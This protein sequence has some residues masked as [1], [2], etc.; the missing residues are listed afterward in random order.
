MRIPDVSIVIAT[1]NRSALLERTLTSILEQDSSEGSFEVIVVDNN[2]SDNTYGMVQALQRTAGGRLRYLTESRQGNAYAR[3]TG[4]SAALAPVIAF[5]DDDVCVSP[6]W[7][8]TI[9]DAFAR[10]DSASFIGGRVLPDWNGVPPQWLTRENWAPIAAV[11]YGEE[12]VA[13]NAEHSVCLLTANLAIRRS[14]LD[15]IG[16]FNPSLQRVKEGIGSLEDH[17]LIARLCRAGE[18]GVYLPGMCASTHIAE[19][20]LSK[21]YHRRWHRGHGKFYAILRDPEFERSRSLIFRAPAHVYR[22]M[23]VAMIGW[24]ACM[25]LRRTH[26][27]FRFESQLWFS[28]GYLGQRL[29]EEQV[30]EAG[31]STGKQGN[32]PTAAEEEWGREPHSLSLVGRTISMDYTAAFMDLAIGMFMLPFNMAHL[33]PSAYGL[34][35]LAIAPT[36]YFSMLDLGYGV[37]LSKTVT[38]YRAQRNAQA[39]R[40]IISTMFFVFT[41]VGLVAYGIAIILAQGIARIADITPETAATGRQIVLVVSVYI[42]LGFPVSAFGAVVSGFQRRYLNGFVSITTSVIVA[43]VNIIVLLSGYGLIEVVVCTTIVRCLSCIGYRLTAYRVFPALRIRFHYFRWSRLREVTRFS[44][45][46][47]LSDLSNKLTYATAT[48]VI[49]A[50]LNTAAVAVWTVAQRL[51]DMAQRLTDQLNGALFP[52]IVDSATHGNTDRL[53]RVL[54]QGTGISLALVMPLC[55]GLAVLAD[56][57]VSLWVGPRFTQ[58]VVIVQALAAVVVIRVGISASRQILQGAGHHSMVAYTDIAVGVATL[59]LSVVLA[60]KMGMLGAAL[61]TLIPVAISSI[62]VLLPAACIRASVSVRQ[63]L[64]KAIWPALWPTLCMAA[65]LLGT[66]TYFGTGVGALLAQAALGGSVYV[67]LYICMAV[68]HV[69]RDW[70][71]AKLRTLGVSLRLVQAKVA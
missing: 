19:E 28:L 71:L 25:V 38:Q 20:R 41:L 58:A 43:V 1:Y 33:G 39:I 11:D 8:K 40:E 64:A 21:R 35:I 52:V 15:R 29:S 24:L 66:R 63:I 54:L 61:G 37:A 53:K 3:N 4:V 9:C 36:M 69:E 48:L 18:Q 67:L 31:D 17:D 32:S 23:I 70:Y 45:F 44:A 2:S 14:V 51:S 27:A 7:V 22:T 26:A 59:V 68:D 47:L 10:Y 57:L 12:P 5:T 49:G 6:N 55:M 34:W 65:L 56:S 60:R 46:M 16:G 62:A 30:T 42:A 13:V 50:I